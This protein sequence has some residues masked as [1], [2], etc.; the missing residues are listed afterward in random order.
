MFRVLA[1]T[2]LISSTRA[3][4]FAMIL[5]EVLAEVYRRSTLGIDIIMTSVARAL[6][7]TGCRVHN[8]QRQRMGAKR[9]RVPSA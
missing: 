1:G 8:A 7:E 2:F 6:R 9:A 5:M 4:D 3:S